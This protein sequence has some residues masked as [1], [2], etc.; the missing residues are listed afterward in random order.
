[1]KR[2]G[3]FTLFEIMVA[4]VITSVV[5]L[6]AYGTARAGFD[7][8]ERLADYRGD[9]EAQAIVRALLVDA[10]R[11]PIAGG[12]AAMNDVLFALDDAVSA[13]GLPMDAVRFVSRGMSGSAGAATTWLV[14]LAPSDS[15]V[16]L[17]AVPDSSSDAQPVDA[18]LR[19]ARGLSVHVLART[20]DSIWSPRW[21]VIGRV[22]AGIAIA[23]LAADGRPVGPPLVVHA[24]LEAI[25]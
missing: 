25:R 23:F 22:P 24:A 18:L 10:L 19:S 3:G 21:D 15:G 20:A 9:V 11:H 2:R 7:T 6:L 12:G 5:A 14:T 8:E 16:R 13:S 1:M 17:V 4:I